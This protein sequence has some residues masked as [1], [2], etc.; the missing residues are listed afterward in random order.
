MGYDGQGLGKRRKGI[1]ISIVAAPKVK[2]EGLGFHS[3]GG[4]TISMNITFVKAKNMENL[5]CSSE[6]RATTSEGGSPLLPQPSCGGLKKGSDEKSLKINL[7][8]HSEETS[9]KSNK[10]RITRPR[11][12]DQSR[13]PLFV[14][15]V[16]R[17]AT[18]LLVVG[19]Q[20][21][22]KKNGKKT[23]PNQQ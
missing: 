2:H 14:I 16:G 11:G 5:A 15:V 4:N 23:S 17:K 1:L 12:L 20:W 22:A 10:R 8:H 9:N 3:E 21:Y 13:H 7:H 18:T 19:T 6:G